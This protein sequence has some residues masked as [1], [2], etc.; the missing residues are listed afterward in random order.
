MLITKRSSN[1]I[2]EE[3][4]QKRPDLHLLATTKLQ[5][6][7]SYYNQVRCNLQLFYYAGVGAAAHAMIRPVNPKWY[8]K[9]EQFPQ[10][11][12]RDFGDHGWCGDFFL[13]CG[14][15]VCVVRKITAVNI[16]LTGQRIRFILVIQFRELT[17]CYVINKSWV[18]IFY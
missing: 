9:A 14:F 2:A 7:G 6:S 16:E 4:Y 11:R 17:F 18:K 10:T 13:Q 3:L 15:R 5:L 1:A 12:E 8:E